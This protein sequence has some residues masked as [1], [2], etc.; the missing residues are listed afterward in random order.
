MDESWETPVQTQVLLMVW[1]GTRSSY[2]PAGS[3]EGDFTKLSACVPACLGFISN[4]S[5]AWIASGTHPHHPGCLHQHIICLDTIP[6]LSPACWGMYH[7]HCSGH[8]PHHLGCQQSPAWLCTSQ[9]PTLPPWAHPS[10]LIPALAGVPRW[11]RPA[12]SWSSWVPWSGCG[13]EEAAPTWMAAGGRAQPAAPSARPSAVLPCSWCCALPC[14]CP[15][16][17]MWDRWLLQ[18]LRC[19]YVGGGAGVPLFL[20]IGV[21]GSWELG[22]PRGPG[23]GAVWGQEGVG[24]PFLQCL[25]GASASA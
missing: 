11:Q 21:S 16:K 15:M 22:I 5:P 8:Y 2:R 25:K 18:G 24:L 9:A 7:P 10:P 4:I 3:S 6:S 19:F 20:C 13:Q 17:L 1:V 14:L 23:I 12:V